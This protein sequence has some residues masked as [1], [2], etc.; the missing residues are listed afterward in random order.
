[1]SGRAS[2][3]RV[4]WSGV[5][6]EEW[7][8]SGCSAVGGPSGYRCGVGRVP[9]CRV[10]VMG[11]R[12]GSDGPLGAPE[13][14]IVFAGAVSAS[15]GEVGLL[16]CRWRGTGESVVSYKVAGERGGP[17][18]RLRSPF[19]RDASPFCMMCANDRTD[20]YED[21]GAC[22][23]GG[24]PCVGDG[25]EF[26]SE[27][28]RCRSRRPRFCRS[29]SFHLRCSRGWWLRSSCMLTGWAG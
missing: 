18:L 9:P 26:V 23:A 6:V 12:A 28:S 7:L 5:V 2:R 21:R 27:H 29:L 11:S 15:G 10:G 20:V 24:R 8:G 3:A 1:M 13:V 25:G 17:G 19:D 14:V 4:P 22:L 16:R